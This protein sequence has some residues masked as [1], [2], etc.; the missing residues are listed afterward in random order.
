MASKEKS[1]PTRYLN[2]LGLWVFR[3][4]LKS[5]SVDRVLC[6]VADLAA[7]A[8]S[9]SVMVRRPFRVSTVW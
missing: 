4:A 7:D 2:G 1:A 8:S 5:L 9:R 6:A 3:H